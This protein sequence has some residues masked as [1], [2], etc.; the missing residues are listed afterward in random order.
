MEKYKIATA[1]QI[2]LSRFNHPNEKIRDTI[3]DVLAR[4]A[5]EYPSQSAWWIFHFLYFDEKQ[6]AKKT[7]SR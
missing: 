6:V 4:L 7:V 3:Q 1:L 5:V 2:L